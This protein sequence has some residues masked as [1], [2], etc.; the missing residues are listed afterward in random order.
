M[1]NCPLCKRV[2]SCS[3]LQS[4]CFSNVPPL[5]V[6]L[7]VLVHTALCPIETG[8]SFQNSWDIGQESGGRRE[9]AQLQSIITFAIAEF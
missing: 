9:C 1:E 3:T 7:F 4:T 2:G 6:T 8:A 5:S